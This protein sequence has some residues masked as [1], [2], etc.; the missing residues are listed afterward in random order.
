MSGVVR[1]NVFDTWHP[2]NISYGRAPYR[3]LVNDP[4]DP[5]NPA[6]A[7]RL[8]WDWEPNRAYAIRNGSSPGSRIYPFAVMDV[9]P[10]GKP[11]QADVD[12]DGNG[13]VD[14]RSELGWT[15]SDDVAG[16][17][18]G[19]YYEAVEHAEGLPTGT[20]LGTRP[21]FRKRYGDKVYDGGIVWECFDNRV[22]V[23]LLQITIRYRDPASNLSRQVTIRHSL[24]DRSE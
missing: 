24:T 16:W 5:S 15:G 6:P 9:G 19:V 20:S 23:S 14:D 22:G 7:P 17:Y 3:P 13:I 18:D 10:D 1:N 4:L 12:D 2:N 21:A 8:T 11:G